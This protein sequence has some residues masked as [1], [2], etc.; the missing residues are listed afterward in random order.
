MSVKEQIELFANTSIIVAVHGA[1][2]GNIKLVPKTAIIFELFPEYY[3][4]SSYRIQA[5][6]LGLKYYYMIGKSRI[7]DND[8][9][10]KDNL[11]VEIKLLKKALDEII[12]NGKI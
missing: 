4:D 3:H 2:L 12:D 1:G 8:Q 5:K 11:F 9:P 7:D 10:F 6:A